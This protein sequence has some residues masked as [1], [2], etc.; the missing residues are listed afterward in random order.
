LGTVDIRLLDSEVVYNGP[1]LCFYKVPIY[2]PYDVCTPKYTEDFIFDMYGVAQGPVG[3]SDTDNYDYMPF[4][5]YF[6]LFPSLVNYPTTSY[7]QGLSDC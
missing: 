5:V 4:R 7:E 3:P 2:S 1:V 6:D